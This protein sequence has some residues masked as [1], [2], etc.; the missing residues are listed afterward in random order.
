MGNFGMISPAMTQKFHASKITMEVHPNKIDGISLISDN[1]FASQG[2][3]N[4]SAGGTTIQK[5]S[6]YSPSGA[7]GH[8]TVVNVLQ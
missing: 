6:A 1:L 5:I 2:A 7:S 8:T 4:N 3:A